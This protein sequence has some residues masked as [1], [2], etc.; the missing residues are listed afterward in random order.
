MEIE[1][2]INYLTNRDLD[3][4]KEIQKHVSEG[5]ACTYDKIKVQEYLEKIISPKCCVCRKPLDSDIIIVNDY[6]MHKK[7]RK[8]YHG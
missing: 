1:T 3:R 8:K 5:T 4:L 7:C 6:K 2:T